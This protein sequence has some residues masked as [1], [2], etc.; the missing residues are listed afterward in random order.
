MPNIRTVFV[1]DDATD[2]LVGRFSPEKL[3]MRLGIS[4]EEALLSLADDLFRAREWQWAS[5][6]TERLLKNG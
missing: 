1:A 6:R 3:L 4:C 5:E 2:V